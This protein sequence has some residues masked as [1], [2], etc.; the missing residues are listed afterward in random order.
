MNRPDGTTSVT[1]LLM[2]SNAHEISLMQSGSVREVFENAI[3]IFEEVND[4]SIP[5]NKDTWRLIYFY[6]RAKKHPNYFI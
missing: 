6:I 3:R 5:N 1:K 2:A 4:E